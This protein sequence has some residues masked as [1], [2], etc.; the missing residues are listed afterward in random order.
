MSG[1]E[2]GGVTNAQIMHSLGQLTGSVQALHQGL[3]ARIED[4]RADIRRLEVNQN[5]RMDRIEDGLGQR[6]DNVEANV[7]QRV[8]DI[9]DAINKR[10]DGLGSR[11]TNL[12]AE[13]KK[14]IEKVAKQ[15]AMGGGIGGALV[16]GA[17]EIIKHL[18]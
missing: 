13:D 3:V 1:E 7:G 6:I 9:S 4:M 12:E 18:S 8:T 5:D 16:T 14:I 10:I 17:V 11:V 2:K 15:A